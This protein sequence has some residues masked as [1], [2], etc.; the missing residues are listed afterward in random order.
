VAQHR[1]TLDL[2]LAQLVNDDM[3]VVIGEEII[4]YREYHSDFLAFFDA[5][6]IEGPAGTQ[7]DE[8]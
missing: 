2:L 5:L 7:D 3:Y 1:K 6:S 8:A 4:R